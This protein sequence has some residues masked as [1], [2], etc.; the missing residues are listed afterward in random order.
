M[1]MTFVMSQ[2]GI[3]L[4][5]LD[6]GYGLKKSGDPREVTRR[7]L[8]HHIKRISDYISTSIAETDLNSHHHH[9]GKIFS[10]ME[11]PCEFLIY[12]LDSL[13]SG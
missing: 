7:Q 13:N 1:V 9:R 3:P 11:V 2:P 10:T 4:K 8:F 12:Y 5:K 6:G